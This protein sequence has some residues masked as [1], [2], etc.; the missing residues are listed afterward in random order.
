MIRIAITA[1]AFKAIKGDA[2][3]RRA[4]VA[5]LRHDGQVPRLRRGEI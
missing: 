4:S 5:R 3:R 1:A 2:A